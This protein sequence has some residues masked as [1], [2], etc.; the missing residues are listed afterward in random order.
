MAATSAVHTLHPLLEVHMTL[1]K[2][3]AEYVK[4][5][6]LYGA[7]ATSATMAIVIA[8]WPLKFLP[9]LILGAMFVHGLE[10][11]H[12]MMHQRHFGKRWGDA[13]GFLLG[14]PMFIEFTEY[15]LSHSHHHR[16]VGTPEDDEEAP[17]YS[18]VPRQAVGSFCLDLLLLDHYW[19]ILQNAGW[20]AIGNTEAIRQ[21]MG[22]SGKHAPKLAIQRITRGYR[23]MLLVLLVAIALSGVAHTDIFIQLWLVPLLFAG[24]IH[25]LVELP[26]HWG[27]STTS[28]D[29]MVNTRTIVPSRFADWYTNG[30]CWHV[31]HHCKPAMPMADLP[32]LHTTLQPQMQC[33]SRGYLAFYQEFFT[34][35]LQRRQ[36]A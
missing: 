30:N 12:E 7:I 19:S 23:V 24:P 21:E 16:A 9:Q 15:R 11:Q 20:A 31:E 6:A 32:V 17:A 27:C 28:T 1:T 18:L 33:L 36:L 22:N 2:P 25:A 35:L 10:L 4:K 5:L 34:A 29:I 3:A 8:P 13:I 14:L 26:E